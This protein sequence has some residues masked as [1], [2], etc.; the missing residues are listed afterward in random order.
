[1]WS[2]IAGT[3]LGT[4]SG[5]I[6]GLHPNNLIPFFF[7]F[8][9]PGMFAVSFYASHAISVPFQSIFLGVSSDANALAIMPGHKLALKGKGLLAFKQAS[10]TAFF[11]VLSS[12]VFILL[13]QF[14]LPV[15]SSFKL[16]ILL[17][18]TILLA[19]MLAGRKILVTLLAGALGILCADYSMLFPM[20]SGFFGASTLLLSMKTESLPRQ[21]EKEQSIVYRNV[22]LS[23]AS[24][25]FFAIVPGASAGIA[26]AFSR[27]FGRIKKEEYVSSVAGISAAYTMFSIYT[28]DVYGITRSGLAVFLKPLNMSLLASV[29]VAV[30]SAGIAFPLSLMLAERAC[31]NIHHM[32]YSLIAGSSFTLL[33]AMVFAFTGSLGIIVFITST[34]IGLLAA[35]M[36]VRRINCM[37]A[38]II[39]VLLRALI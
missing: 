1:M 22:F 17:F 20:L 30:F 37:S 32:Q 4:V 23:Q 8:P 10:G 39:P 3:L 34:S 27:V 35:S 19:H 12:P 2:A 33:F 24:A 25:F 7:F 28:L 36:H 9:D 26:A 18:L 5:F 13:Y 15:Y 11:V 38:I 16:L 14:M 29:G 21:K 31:R 6:P